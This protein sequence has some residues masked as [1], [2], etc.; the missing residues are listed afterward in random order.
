MFDLDELNAV[1]IDEFSDVVTLSHGGIDFQVKGI[2]EM[3]T[4]SLNG[5][6]VHNNVQPMRGIYTLEVMTSDIA[7]IGL[8]KGD[9]AIIKGVTYKL[10]DSPLD[11]HGMTTLVLKK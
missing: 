1:M 9:R 11:V 10:D 8:Q 4:N 7:E 3:G 5:D 6:P 2:F